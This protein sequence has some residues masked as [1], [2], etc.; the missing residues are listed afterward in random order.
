MLEYT[1]RSIIKLQKQ[2]NMLLSSLNYCTEDERKD[3][4]EELNKIEE[5]ILNATNDVYIEEYDRLVNK[6]TYLLEE[7]LSRLE[8]LVSLI[9]ERQI[10]IKERKKSHM[11]ITGKVVDCPEILGESL[12]SKFKKNIQI[13]NKY[14]KNSVERKKLSNENEELKEKEK[15]CLS[16]LRVN[17]KANEELEKKLIELLYKSFTSIDAFKLLDNNLEIEN[18]FKE[19]SYALEKAKE[20]V[21]IANNSFNH[22]DALEC[23]DMYNEINSEYNICFEKKMLLELILIYDKKVEN[24]EELLAKRE[25]IN[26]IL[27]NIVNSNFYKLVYLEV[28]KQYNT[29]KIEEQDVKTYNTIKRQIEN[30]TNLISKIDEE[31]NSKEFKGVLDVLIQNEKARQEKIIAEQRKKEYE[32]RQ[33]QLI[34]EAKKQEEIKRRQELIEEARREKEKKEKELIL[35]QKMQEEQRKKEQEERMKQ[36]LEVQN[37]SVLKPKLTDYL[38]EE[39]EEPKELPV[40]TIES[41]TKKIFIPNEII[42][43]DEDNADGGSNDN[44]NNI[45]ESIYDEMKKEKDPSKVSIPVINNDNLV[46]KKVDEQLIDKNKINSN[47]DNKDN[48]FTNDMIFPDVE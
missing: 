15:K 7:E 25:K 17:D 18:Q 30:N 34:L 43:D 28:A 29:L 4:I 10:Y 44:V 12:I 6:E 19:L 22:I 39:K 31:N 11:E 5:K 47:I 26:D 46:A 48:L 24:F 23:R 1:N 2:Y 21:D 37:N 32:E 13:I 20:N 16:K 36:I 33:K 41:K 14:K 42:F 27:N 35:K 3:F 45:F 9:E 38:E 8:Q 40:S